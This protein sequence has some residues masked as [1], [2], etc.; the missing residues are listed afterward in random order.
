MQVARLLAVV[1]FVVAFALWSGLARSGVWQDDFSE[2]A[3]A[4]EW[5]GD[6]SNFRLEEGRLVG[7][8]AHPLLTFL[9]VVEVG[10]GWADYTAQC[11]VN[12]VTPNL[13]ICAKGGIVL[14]RPGEWGIV[15]AVHPPAGRLEV[16]RLESREPLLSVVRNVEW[17]RWYHLRVNAAGPNLVFSVD[18]QR[19]GQV[20][21][22][23]PPG[24]F[25]PGE[26][27]VGLAVEDTMQTLF[28]D[29]RVEGPR[30]PDGGHRTAP[31]S[32]RGR[33]ALRWAELKQH[34]AVRPR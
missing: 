11:R 5:R 17:K 4:V 14:R 10:Q 6:R 24:D 28:D 3:L 13:A 27:S 16:F 29:F 32:P 33:V 21:A 31:V 19:I 20:V 2:Q 34:R 18:G 8:S 22:E 7:A 9:R 30:I 26:G 1:P 23:A 12:V 15:L 25:R